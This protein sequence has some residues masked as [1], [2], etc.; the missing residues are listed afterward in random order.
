VDGSEKI[1]IASYDY[2]E[3]LGKL[4]SKTQ[5]RTLANYLAWR[6]TKPFMKLLNEEARKI[7]Q[8]YRKAINGIQVTAVSGRMI[9]GPFFTSPLAPRVKFVP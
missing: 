5:P 3:K 7:R 4:V 1:N 6:I 2:L 8:R 9:R